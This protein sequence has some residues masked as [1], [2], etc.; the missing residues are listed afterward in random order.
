VAGGVL[1]ITG[2]LLVLWRIMTRRR[3][4]R[5]TERVT[6][7]GDSL[8][9]R[10]FPADDAMLYAHPYP[11]GSSKKKLAA[12]GRTMPVSRRPSA[13]DSR[14]LVQLELRSL[15]SEKGILGHTPNID[16]DARA[17]A[18]DARLLQLH[19]EISRLRAEIPNVQLLQAEIDRLRATYEEEA[20]PTYSTAG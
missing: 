17:V 5:L 19:E 20:P 7:Q 15:P 13:D 18:R 16:D 6:G 2:A 11:I 10:N 9:S 4:K 12:P 14:S 8:D 3:R 1:L